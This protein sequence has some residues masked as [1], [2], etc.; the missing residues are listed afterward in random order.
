M[1]V[2]YRKAEDTALTP[3]FD[4]I[5]VGDAKAEEVLPDAVAEANRIMEEEQARP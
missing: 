4:K 1:P 5:W 3:V 2:G